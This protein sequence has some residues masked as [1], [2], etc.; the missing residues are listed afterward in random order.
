ME[1]AATGVEPSPAAMVTGAYGDNSG[2][3]AVSAGDWD[4]DGFDDVAISNELGGVALYWGGPRSI[5]DGRRVDAGWGGLPYS[6]PTA[7]GDGGGLAVLASLDDETVGVQIE[8]APR[9]SRPVIGSP[10]DPPSASPP[11]QTPSGTP[12]AASIGSG[13][14]GCDTSAGAAGA[15]SILAAIGL[16]AFAR[17]VGP[18][19]RRTDGLAHGE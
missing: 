6:P 1:G 18:G 10:T 4:G 8:L 11:N 15:T 7:L 19:R 2:S 12:N 13:T 17:R 9:K 5:S 14:S 16:I 3:L